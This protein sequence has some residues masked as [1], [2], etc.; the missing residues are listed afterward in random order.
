MLSGR[1]V[2]AYTSNVFDRQYR[3]LW[4]SV[5]NDYYFVF[6]IK[7]CGDAMVVLAPSVGDIHLAFEIGIGLD[8]NTQSIIR[9]SIQGPGVMTVST[10]NILSCNESRPFWVGWRDGHIEVGKGNIPGQNRFMSYYNASSAPRTHAVA[11]QT[12]WGNSGHWTIRHTT[13]DYNIVHLVYMI[14]AW[15]S[16]IKFTQSFKAPWWFTTKT[17]YSV[18]IQPGL[19]RTDVVHLV[20]AIV[21]EMYRTL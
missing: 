1:Q 21:K 7:A 16:G 12:G 14:C 3:T 11:V 19:L 9:R 2:S 8:K 5:Y 20:V 18:M 4:R 6:E 10:L 13:G 17:V 15:S